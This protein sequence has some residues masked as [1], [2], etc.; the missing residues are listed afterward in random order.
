MSENALI[1][2]IQILAIYILFS[3]G[4][5]LGSVRIYTANKF[6]SWF[7]LKASRYIQK[8][9]WDCF[10]CMASVWTIVLTHDFS[11]GMILLV[12]GINFLIQETFLHETEA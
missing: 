1:L 3:Q 8:P 7:G 10:P 6:D 2:S 11:I 4:M 9:L 12:C 5:L